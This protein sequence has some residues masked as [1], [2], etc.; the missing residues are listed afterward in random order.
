VSGVRIERPGLFTTI[1]DRG[2]PGYRSFGVPAAGAFDRESLDLAN[3]LAGNPPGVA[4]LELTRLGPTLRALG[5]VYVAI[6]G[7]IIDAEIESEHGTCRR[8]PN[9]GAFPLRT[10]DRLITGPIRHGCRAYLAIHD[11]FQ[12]PMILGSRSDETPM[13]PGAVLPARTATGPVLILDPMWAAPT[14]G[15]QVTLRLLAG[16]DAQAVPTQAWEGRTLR[17][18]RECNRMGLA[19]VEDDGCA[20]LDLPIDPNRISAP[21]APGALQWTGTRWLLLG[22]AGGTMGGYPHAAQLI[23]ADVDRLGQCLPGQRL[24]LSR[25]GVE[26]A[27]R[28]DQEHRARVERRAIIVRT[29]ALADLKAEAGRTIE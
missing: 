3:A 10:G 19:L 26:E 2:R 18:G 21:V 22:V 16:P 9:P 24:R 1:Q 12:L 28:I 27:R 15:D 20:S 14:L 29:R 11:G 17:V 23:G 8:V 5:P 6:A 7:S 25:V 4:A 13:R